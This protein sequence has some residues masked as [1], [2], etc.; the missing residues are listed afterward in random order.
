M[1]CTPQ[2]PQ[3]HPPAFLTTI[4]HQI[5]LT[6]SR[7]AVQLFQQVQS[8][9]VRTRYSIQMIKVYIKEDVPIR[10]LILPIEW[11]IRQLPLIYP[12]NNKLLQRTELD[13]SAIRNQICLL[14]DTTKNNELG[15]NE[16]SKDDNIETKLKNKL[17]LLVENIEGSLPR[18]ILEQVAFDVLN[19]YYTP[20]SVIL[21][22]MV[23]PVIN[24]SES[25]S[26]TSALHSNISTPK[27]SSSETITNKSPSNT[28]SIPEEENIKGKKRKLDNILDNKQT[29]SNISKK[30]RFKDI[31]SPEEEEE[32]QQQQQQV[33]EEEGIEEIEE[34]EI[35]EESEKIE[36]ENDDEEVAIELIQELNRQF[37]K[38][39]PKSSH[40]RTKQSSSDQ[41]TTTKTMA[42][43]IKFKPVSTEGKSPP[44][45]WLFETKKKRTPW[46][47]EEERN[48]REGVNHYGEGHWAEILRTYKFKSCRDSTSLRDKWRILK[49]NETLK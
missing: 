20:G 5:A 49:K 41:Q 9:H 19:G 32:Q 16:T 45:P 2:N 22:R 30:T 1:V 33:V 44:K 15:T 47:A 3:S 14:L 31:E 34:E 17:Q 26:N 43:P 42:R 6:V 37:A 40:L 39:F 21:S 28:I 29:S 13:L 48:L 11:I 27:A 25:I 18:P 23:K 46:T 7:N 24:Q 36:E 38:G 10:N 12:H 35:G 8:Y 4:K